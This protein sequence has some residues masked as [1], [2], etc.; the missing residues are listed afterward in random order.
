MGGPREPL[1]R[2][3]G[4][5]GRGALGL[6]EGGLRRVETGCESRISGNL[7][8][9]FCGFLRVHGGRNGG[10]A[11][12]TVN[13]LLTPPDDTARQSVVAVDLSPFWAYT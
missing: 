8:P 4:K 1:G 5:P 6:G 9:V 2:P 11:D 7:P 13:G 10:N 12:K 3:F